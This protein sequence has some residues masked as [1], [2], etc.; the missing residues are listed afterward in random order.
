MRVLKTYLSLSIPL[1][2]V[3]PACNFV[4]EQGWA[5]YWAT[6]EWSAREIEE[7]YHV[8]EKLNLITLVAEQCQ[9]QYVFNSLFSSD[10]HDSSGMF[11]RERPEKE[12]ER[13]FLC[14]YGL[15]TTTFSSLAEGLPTS[16]SGEG[17]ERIQKTKEITKIAEGLG[18]T[19]TAVALAWVAG[20]PN[21]SVV[22]LGTPSKEQL[23]Q[24]LEAVKVL[25]KLTPEVLE[26]IE[27]VL[28]NKPVLYVSH[29]VDWVDLCFVQSPVDFSQQA[30]V[31]QV[32]SSAK[33][34]RTKSICTL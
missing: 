34:T 16:K 11:Y 28:K 18:T 23:L 21:A 3:V 30:R 24:N 1:E 25:P 29:V 6:S 26:Q 4:I 2:E 8:A 13:P 7:A 19:I 22:I 31:G 9:H 33:K 5:F 27:E 20:N 14:K 32:W 10:A 17:Q 12:Y 15:A